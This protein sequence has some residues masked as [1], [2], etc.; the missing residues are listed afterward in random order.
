M[1]VPLRSRVDTST[2]PVGVLE[3]LGVSAS[4]VTPDVVPEDIADEESSTR[5]EVA[6]SVSIGDVTSCGM[7]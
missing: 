2:D 5:G 7:S 6:D 1:I 4:E 3:P